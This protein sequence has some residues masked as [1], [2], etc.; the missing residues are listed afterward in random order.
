MGRLIA[1][2]VFIL[3]LRRFEHN[4]CCNQA[5]ALIDYA[6]S[7]AAQKPIHLQFWKCLNLQGSELAPRPAPRQ[8]FLE[9]WWERFS[10]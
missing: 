10:R 1:G 5:I 2:V 4:N 6:G 3:A 8:M 7:N 9:G